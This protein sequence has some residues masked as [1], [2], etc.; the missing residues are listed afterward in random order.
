MRLRRV[1]PE[2]GVFEVF[3]FSSGLYA[4][5]TRRLIDYRLGVAVQVVTVPMALAGTWVSGVVAPDILKAIL[6]VS[7][8]AVAAS[9]LRAPSHENVA[10]IDSD[11]R[12]KEAVKPSRT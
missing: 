8:F 1:R 10:L 3:G 5:A 11:I 6:G 7:L 9:F 4:H 12:R 2:G